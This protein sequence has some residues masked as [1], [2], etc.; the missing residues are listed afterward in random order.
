MYK[1]VFILCAFLL[2]LRIFSIGE[3]SLYLMYCSQS[4]MHLNVINLL[5]VRTFHR[6]TSFWVTYNHVQML[7]TIQPVPSQFFRNSL[8][9]NIK[10]FNWVLQHYTVVTT[11]YLAKPMP[12]VG[13][14]VGQTRRREG[15][16]GSEVSPRTVSKQASV[17]TQVLNYE[18]I[19]Q[20]HRAAVRLFL[21]PWHP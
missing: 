12:S 19:N 10:H 2:L 3:T 13:S 14:W 11:D 15:F 16:F 18:E 7:N 5:Y 8:I 9:F 21:F 6:L 17:L 4:M 1:L 20:L